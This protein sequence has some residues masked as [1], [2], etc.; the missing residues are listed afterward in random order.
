[1]PVTPSLAQLLLS[2]LVASE[3]AAAAT[4]CVDVPHDLIPSKESDAEQ[5]VMVVGQSAAFSG[6]H[7]QTGLDMR[8]GIEAAFAL[9]NETSTV[10]FALASLD[11][12][13]DDER[14]KLNVEQLLCTGA[15][16]MGPAFAIAGT[17]GSTASE[18]ALRAMTASV[19]AGVAPV[20]YIGALSGSQVLRT[21]SAVMQ[22]AGSS[23]QRTGVVLAR[24]GLRDEISAIVA[25]LS[26]EWD[27]LSATAVFYEDTEFARDAVDFLNESLKSLSTALFS[28]YGH[29]TVTDPGD[30][31]SMAAEAMAELYANGQPQALVLLAGA[32]MSGALLTEMASQS[33]QEVVL[34][35]TSLVTADELY[36]AVS[37]STWDTLGEQS[38]LYMAQAVP[39]PTEEDSIAMLKYQPEMDLTHVSLEGFIVGRLV[40]IA[41][42]RALELYGWPLTRANFLD[43]IFRDIRTFKL[44]SSYNL[45]PYGDGV[46]T[47]GAAQT[48]GDWCNQGAHQV[49]MT[50]MNMTDGTLMDG[51]EAWSFK[52][53]G[54]S[55]AVGNASMRR[56]IVGYDNIL[57]SVEGSDFQ[58][59]L[60]A[61][62]SAH[63]SGSNR[64]MAM[65]ATMGKNATEGIGDLKDREVRTFSFAHRL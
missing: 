63:N 47:E 65:S 53:S 34:V 44:H 10:K 18:A 61:A 19:R 42:A 3:L 56:A 8:A 60:S 27:L 32:D 16:G 30:L 1:M 12:A 25:L 33:D 45:G 55:A 46:G 59:G 23:G 58:I 6:P 36:A 14:Q 13:Y 38:P 64:P 31:S 24:P 48:E 29:A 11:D 39:L 57:N 15:S 49:F 35:T 2:C 5:V 43:T 4:Q 7:A 17:V 21:Q 51:L 50:A 54:C 26:S 9:A 22:N 41:A 62:I 28:S 52:F 20:P 37:Q 40:T